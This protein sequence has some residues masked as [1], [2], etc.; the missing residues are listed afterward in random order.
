MATL[1]LSA[2]IPGEA[3]QIVARRATCQGIQYTIANILG[4]HTIT[5]NAGHIGCS[6]G[7]DRCFLTC[8]HIRIVE[9]QEAARRASYEAT[10]DLSYGC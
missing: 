6:C 4:T 8:E 2:V 3:T 5:I 7:L 1:N 10:F 9:A